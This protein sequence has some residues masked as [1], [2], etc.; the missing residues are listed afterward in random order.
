MRGSMIRKKRGFWTFIFS[1]CPGAG[2]MYLGF[3]KM[4]VS[5]MGLTFGLIG[6]SMMIHNKIFTLMLP[7]VWFYSF[8]HVHNMIALPDEEF[9]ALEDY[10]IFD[11]KDEHIKGMLHTEK[12]AKIIGTVIV[13]IGGCLLLE[14]FRDLFNGIL[15]DNVMRYLYPFF[16]DIPKIVISLI[17]LFAGVL[18]I[19]GKK[20]ELDEEETKLLEKKED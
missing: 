4:G 19:K 11:I 20:E 1:L 13:I 12:T 2:E 5:L 10:Y 9:Y 16:D 18:L 6:I 17:I 7:V 8:C 3:S 15:P 14:A